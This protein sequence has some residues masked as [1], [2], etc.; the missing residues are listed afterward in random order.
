MS[1]PAWHRNAGEPPIFE[2][3]DEGEHCPPNLIHVDEAANASVYVRL[4]NGSEP[5]RPWPVYGRPA[6]TRWSI[7]GSPFDIK[8]WRRA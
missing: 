7:E 8:D 1:A 5:A 3:S 6:R 4:R 2:P